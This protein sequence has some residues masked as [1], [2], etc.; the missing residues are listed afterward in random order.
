MARIHGMTHS[1]MAGPKS[2]HD[3]AIEEILKLL[4]KLEFLFSR[5]LFDRVFTFPSFTLTLEYFRI[6]EI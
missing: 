4:Y 2:D 1:E 5:H 6:D 3:H